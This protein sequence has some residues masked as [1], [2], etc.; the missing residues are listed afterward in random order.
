MSQSQ[1]HAYD[2]KSVIKS[3]K[4]AGRNVPSGKPEAT[5]FI[6]HSDKPVRLKVS[7]GIDIDLLKA[8]I[9]DCPGPNRILLHTS[10]GV[11]SLPDE[12]N[13]NAASFVERFMA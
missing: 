6:D 11:L 1:A 2:T 3:E 4:F 5:K 9:L 7:D 8:S 13:V 10:Y 12:W